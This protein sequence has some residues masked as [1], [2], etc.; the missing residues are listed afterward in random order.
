[1]GTAVHARAY[2]AGGP[3]RFVSGHFSERL[4]ELGVEVAGH[5]D[6]ERRK[7]PENLPDCDFVIFLTGMI[8]HSF[9]SAIDNQARANSIPVVLTSHKWATAGPAIK[10]VLENLAP[11]LANKIR[12]KTIES[13]HSVDEFED[14]PRAVELHGEEEKMQ[15]DLLN[16]ENDSVHDESGLDTGTAK[17]VFNKSTLEDAAVDLLAENQRVTNNIINATLLGRYG[18]KLHPADLA[19]IR[20]ELNIISP[21]AAWLRNRSSKVDSV[22][23]SSSPP[24]VPTDARSS[25]LVAP[26]FVAYEVNI[27]SG[28]I[29]ILSYA[30]KLV[31]SRDDKAFLT[32]AKTDQYALAQVLME[33][34]NRERIK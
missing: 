30:D 19:R 1:M 14:Q 9:A 8:S 6:Y 27:P 18:H 3:S 16:T 29:K 22:A 17:F 25:V 24:V 11:I 2:I 7:P 26:I 20:R 33:I 15:E 23:Q 21:K 32:L 12:L 34:H 5:F 28:Q 4:A 10:A 31:F 13:I